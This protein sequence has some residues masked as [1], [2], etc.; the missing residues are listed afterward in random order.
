MR[1]EQKLVQHASIVALVS[2]R[3]GEV[4]QAVVQFCFALLIPIGV[5]IFHLG[6]S[7]IA[8]HVGNAFTGSV[9]AFSAGTF[10]CIALSDLLPEVQFHSHDRLKLF[11]A[12]ILGAMLMWGTALIETRHQHEHKRGKSD[13]NAM[14]L[15]Q[16]S[17]ESRASL[18]RR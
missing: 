18:S 17:R 16:S 2:I 11:L 4:D 15:Q 1:E 6:Q 12:F 3:I 5:L 10:I 14:L 7:A 13:P 9:L 8:S